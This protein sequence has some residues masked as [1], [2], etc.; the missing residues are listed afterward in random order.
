MA[1]KA[2]NGDQTPAADADET[3]RAPA[4]DAETGPYHGLEPTWIREALTDLLA[5]VTKLERK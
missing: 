1:A 5:R 2:K 4:A 3:P